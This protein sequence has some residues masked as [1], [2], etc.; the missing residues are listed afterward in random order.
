MAQSRRD[1]A[2]RP[3]CDEELLESSRSPRLRAD[4]LQAP[5]AEEV[6]KVVTGVS[7]GLELFRA[8]Q[9]RALEL[10]AR[11]SRA[12]LG[13]PG[14]RTISPSRSGRWRYSSRPASRSPPITCRSMPIPRSGPTRSLVRGADR[15]D[16]AGPLPTQG[17]EASVRRALEPRES[18][19]PSSPSAAR[20]SSAVSPSFKTGPGPGPQ[21][22]DR[23]GRRHRRVRRGHRAWARCLPHRR[24]GRARDGGR[25]REPRALHRRRPLRHGGVRRAPSRR[26]RRRAIRV[27]HL[28]VDVPQPD[29]GRNVAERPP[30]SPKTACAVLEEPVPC[31]S[32]QVK[33]KEEYLH[34]AIHRP[35]TPTELGREAGMHRREVIAKCMDS[36]CLSSGR[37]DKTLFS[38]SLKQAA[39]KRNSPGRSAQAPGS[40]G[41][42]RGPARRGG[43]PTRRRFP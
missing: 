30:K 42:R 39:Q 41:A 27:E 37:I 22:R 36:G 18:D 9:R 16:Q 7:A 13:R 24:A 38:S 10:V 19:S 8:R 1:G 33:H 4:G 21:R 14:P 15:I 29:I 11:P 17:T 35:S 25:T 34:M 12:V 2:D 43:R 31:L 20:P 26:A 40:P 3:P 32:G 23:L 5:G 28:F 6:T